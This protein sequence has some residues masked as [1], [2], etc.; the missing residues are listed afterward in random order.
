MATRRNAVRSHGLPTI[1]SEDFATGILDQERRPP[2]LIFQR[3]G[4]SRPGGIQV[5]PERIGVLEPRDACRRRLC[6]GG[7]QHQERRRLRIRHAAGQDELPVIPQRLKR[8]R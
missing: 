2:L 7:G 1:W 5:V 4:P 3:H 6:R 8:V